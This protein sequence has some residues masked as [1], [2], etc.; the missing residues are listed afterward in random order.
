[1][2]LA[3]GQVGML[4]R[5]HGEGTSNPSKTCE[6]SFGR[7]YDRYDMALNCGLKFSGIV[8]VDYERFITKRVFEIIINWWRSVVYTGMV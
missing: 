7:M 4:A 2:K 3:R 6:R 5:G 1:M 8:W